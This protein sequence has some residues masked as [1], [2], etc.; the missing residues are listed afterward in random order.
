MNQITRMVEFRADSGSESDGRTLEG[1]AAVFNAN[2]RIRSWEG[3]FE[4]RI[5][6]GAF[7]K[8]LRE[9]K[10]VMQFNH[11]RDSNVGTVPIGTFTK[12]EEDE[13][14][15]RVEGTLYDT[16][17]VEDIRQALASGDVPGM[18]FAFQVVRDEWTD[19]NGKKLRGSELDKLLWDAGDR[20]P[21][22]RTIKEVRMSE[23]GPVM[24]PAYGQTS[25]GVRSEDLGAEERSAVVAEYRR[26][27]VEP[28][29]DETADLTRW[30][31]AEKAWELSRW[32]EAET[33]YRTAY[34]EWLDAEKNYLDNEA[35]REGTSE[36]QESRSEADRKVTS[37]KESKKKDN[38]ERK[39]AMTLTELREMLASAEVRKEELDAE[40]RDSEMEGEVLREYDEATANIPKLTARIDAIEK[41]MAEAKVT[42]R[43]APGVIIQKSDAE[44]FNVAE[45]I[46]TASSEDEAHRA[47]R[48]NAKRALD[49]VTIPTSMVR[50]SE[51]KENIADLLRTHDGKAE[52][53]KRILTTGS[54]DYARAWGKAVLAG[55]P[56]GLSGD[57]FRALALGSNGAG[58]YAVPY[59]LDPSVILLTTG[60]DNPLRQ[61]ADHKKITG[62]KWEGVTSAGTSVSRY[63]EAAEVDDDSF[64]L[65]SPEVNTTRVQGFIPFSYE[66]DTAWDAVASEITKALNDAKDHEEE[67]AFTL[68]DGTGLNPFGVIST[69]T[70]LVDTATIGTFA[71][72]DVYAIEDALDT[73]YRR[74]GKFLANHSIYNKVRQFGDV[75]GHKLWERIGA[76]M[77]SELLGYQTYESTAMV[78]T[79]TASSKMLAFGDFK[80]AFVIVDRIGMSVELIPQVFGANGRP[81]GQR[82]IYAI[83]H[84][85]SKILN[86]SALKVMRI[87]AS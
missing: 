55:S 62:K 38:P 57:E 35:A 48:D 9:R 2:T 81:T 25:V 41:R 83:W 46:R 31:E 37:Q 8:T 79:T 72:A 49:K 24:T 16:P 50:E 73:K 20:G 52:I 4:E 11:G 21:L 71:A 54:E 1:Y 61:L 80:R 19:A 47:L 39:R 18:S 84:N 78:A 53:S 65:L 75:D 60:V 22:Q 59:Q 63:A 56:Q 30:L 70:G 33:A 77:P 28:K 66:I 42:A 14:G 64:T 67:T 7:K 87:K 85:G 68:G 13:K 23:C 29:D 86:Q 17:R 26:S 27:I 58:L 5:A 82:G 34:T 74:N 12:L 32:L 76:G 15:L 45:T 40:Y 43:Q 44:I 69:A 6:P 36:N 10:P 51:A 3:D